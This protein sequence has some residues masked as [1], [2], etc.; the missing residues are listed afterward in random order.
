MCS[1]IPPPTSVS[2]WWGGVTRV[3]RASGWGVQERGRGRGG[4]PDGAPLPP[5]PPPPPSP[6]PPHRRAGGGIKHRPSTTPRRSSLNLSFAGAKPPSQP[7]GKR[8]D[9]ATPTAVA[10]DDTTVAF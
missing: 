6:S 5:P 1:L 10:L 4:E 8:V 3:K 9:K 7:W 2:E